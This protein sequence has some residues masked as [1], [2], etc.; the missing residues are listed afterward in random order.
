MNLD[1]FKGLAAA[2][3]ATLLWGGFYPVGRWLLNS[4]AHQPDG[5]TA[6]LLRFAVAS[7]ALAPA[8]ADREAW[9]TLRRNWRRD[10]P[11]FALLAAS[12]IVGEG[13]L[14]LL[15]TKY[16]TAARSALMANTTPI[17]TALLSYWLTRETLSGRKIAGMIS[18]A[19]GIG[20][21]FLL[22]GGDGF[23]G[24]S[25]TLLGVLLAVGAG[26]CWALYTVLG[27][28]ATTGYGAFFC[29]ALLF[30]LGTVMTLPLAAIWGDP[31]GA[32][33]LPPATWVGIAYLGLLAAALGFALWYVALKYLKPGELGAFGYLTPVVSTVLARIF[34]AERLGWGFLLSLALILGG[35]ALMVDRPRRRV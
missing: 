19:A 30:V 5:L 3:I 34:F 12:G 15:S 9:K 22:R 26:I 25:S 10:L 33:E 7:L 1:K 21:M 27:A 29:T 18:G 11:L 32:A 14:V 35:V 17:F 24:G 20:I 31:R 13:V 28:K 16:T 23:S 6:S 8:L 2:L 4:G